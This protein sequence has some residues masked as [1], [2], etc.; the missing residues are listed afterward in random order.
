[1]APLSTCTRVMIVGNRCTTR[2]VGYH[3]PSAPSIEKNNGSF[4]IVVDEDEEDE[5]GGSAM[6]W[7]LSLHLNK[8]R[9]AFLGRMSLM[10]GAMPGCCATMLCRI[11]RCTLLFTR[12]LVTTSDSPNFLNIVAVMMVVI[13]VLN[14]TRE[15]D[16][17]KRQ[18]EEKGRVRVLLLVSLLFVW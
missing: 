18:R 1:M 16:D 3:G 15:D 13:V 9:P 6:M 12:L 17:N 14:E 7:S 4:F 11:P 2:S 8:R 5:G 10:Y